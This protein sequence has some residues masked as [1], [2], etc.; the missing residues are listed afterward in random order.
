MQVALLMDSAS[1]APYHRATV[2]AVGHAAAALGVAVDISAHRT[3]AVPFDDR[4]T[5]VDGVVVG[6]GSP[7]RDE[8]GV[9]S[10]IRRARERGVPLVGT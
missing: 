10:V 3:D 5:G 7:Y 8:P 6:P 4:L 2:E 9:W 1:D